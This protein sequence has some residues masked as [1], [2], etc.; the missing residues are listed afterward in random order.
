[1][2][3]GAILEFEDLKRITGYTRLADVERC[4]S[5]QGVR[6]FFGRG[7]VWTTLDL[8]NA[9]GGI[10]RAAGV[11]EDLYDASLAG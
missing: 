5:N 7:G 3:D 11:E 10:R 9:A 1:M 2:I 6:V 8:I 4:L